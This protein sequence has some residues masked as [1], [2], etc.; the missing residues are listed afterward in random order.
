MPA[1]MKPTVPNTGDTVQPQN[2]EGYCED[3]ALGAVDKGTETAKTSWEGG[4]EA[5]REEVGVNSV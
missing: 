4:N 2:A 1:H 3:P 5:A